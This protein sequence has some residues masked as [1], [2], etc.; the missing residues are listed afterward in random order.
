MPLGLF[1]LSYTAGADVHMY[2]RDWLAWQVAYS[3][4]PVGWTART[5]IL[6]VRSGYPRYRTSRQQAMRRRRPHAM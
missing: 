5:A 2:Y 3:P 4:E 6:A 1:T